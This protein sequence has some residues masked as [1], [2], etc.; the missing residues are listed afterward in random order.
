MDYL[1]G[2]IQIFGLIE[3]GEDESTETNK[4]LCLNRSPHQIDES[5]EEIFGIVR[6][7]SRFRMILNTENR[8]AFMPQ[9][10]DG[11]VVKVDMSHLDIRWKTIGIDRETMIV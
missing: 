2:N 5:F 6:T 1:N 11:I 4:N 9:T 10:G 8:K 7:W 3:P